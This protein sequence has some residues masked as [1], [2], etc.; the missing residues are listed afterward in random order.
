MLTHN[1]V[2]LADRTQPPVGSKPKARRKA[3][4]SW[5]PYGFRGEM[6]SRNTMFKADG[7]FTTG[8]RKMGTVAPKRAKREARG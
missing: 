7:R 4:W 6:N 3:D 1:Y 8:L 5:K 2:A